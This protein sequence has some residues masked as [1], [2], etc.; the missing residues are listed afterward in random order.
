MDLE[1]PTPLSGDALTVEFSTHVIKL[2]K[3]MDGMLRYLYPIKR[4][5][6]LVRTLGEEYE[7]TVVAELDSALNEWFEMIPEN[8]KF[9]TTSLKEEGRLT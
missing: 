7:M 5:E 9:T 1:Y 8:R 2:V 3:I 4:P 6:L